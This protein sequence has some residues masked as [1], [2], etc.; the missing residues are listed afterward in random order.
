L[1]KK[2]FLRIKYGVGPLGVKVPT[3]D[4]TPV[5]TNAVVE[6]LRRSGQRVPQKVPKKGYEFR[7][8]AATFCF[9]KK[10]VSAASTTVAWFFRKEWMA[11]KGEETEEHQ[12]VHKD[13]KRSEGDDVEDIEDYDD[14]NDNSNSPG[15]EDDD[16]EDEEKEFSDSEFGS[17]D[18][19]GND[20]ESERFDDEEEQG[21]HTSAS[22]NNNNHSSSS[23]FVGSTVEQFEQLTSNLS[24]NGKR[25]LNEL[26][27]I[28]AEKESRAER[29]VKFTDNATH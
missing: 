3:K 6:L 22:N 4:R 20:E 9:I 15:S 8:I 26:V 28:V 17:G 25:K 29:R 19:G 7:A 18:E 5:A 21:E 10:A 16:E 1:N 14:N 12:A 27:H 23:A 13:R 11:L 2:D 24:G